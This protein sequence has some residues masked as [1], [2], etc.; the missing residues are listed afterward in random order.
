V[1][2]QAKI[3]RE[4]AQSQTEENLKNENRSKKFDFV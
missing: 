1:Q 3:N 4:L 2:E